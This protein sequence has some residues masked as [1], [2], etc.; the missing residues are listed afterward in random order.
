MKYWFKLLYQSQKKRLFLGVFWALLTVISGVSLLMVSGWFITA[1]ALTGIAISLGITSILNL[2]IPGSGI[3][4]FALSRTISRYIE[5]I[6]NHDTILRL[7]SVFR[8]S[9]FNNLSKS[10]IEQL[11]ARSDSEWLSKLTVNLD[12]LD[13][14]LLRYIVPPIISVLLITILT[15]FTGFIWLDFALYFA[16]FLLFGITSVIAITTKFTAKLSYKYASMMDEFRQKIIEHLSGAFE[17]KSIGLMQH[18][19]QIIIDELA[20]FNSL[21]EQLNAR[22]ANVQLIFDSLLNIALFVVVVSAFFAVNEQLISE[23]QAIML[24]MMLIGTYEVVQ[25]LPNHFSS[26]GQTSFAATRLA[27]LSRS[28]PSSKYKEIKPLS[29]I[30]ID[31]KNHNKIPKSLDTPLSLSIKQTQCVSIIGRSGTGKSTFANLLMGIESIDSA[32]GG[33][34]INQINLQEIASNSWYKKVSYL[35]QSD[36]IFSGTL[37]YNLILGLDGISEGDIWSVLKTVELYDWAINLPDG[38]NYWLGETGG[39]VSGGQARR[40]C[41]ARLLLRS[42]EL[43]VL[44]EPFSNL[45]ES[46]ACRVWANMAPWLAK[47]T[48][49]LLTHETP[50]FLRNKTADLVISLD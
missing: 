28:N 50:Q 27:A 10:T 35:P 20:L 45:D 30:Q 3:R 15:V 44:D 24:V 38:L 36:A 33:I 31:I 8:L 22:I 26:W 25:S 34:Y 13:S 14:L 42:P 1:T 11:R 48:I 17:L 29:D 6:Y 23:A 7:I 19:E 46:M 41:L 40:I 12:A 32:H 18:H 2:Y 4:F 39:I 5:R 16:L 21:Q 37:G 43:V 47:K 9:L 49:V